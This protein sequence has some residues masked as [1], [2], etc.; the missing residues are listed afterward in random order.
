MMLAALV[1]WVKRVLEL[2]REAICPEVDGMAVLERVGLQGL[3]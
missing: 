1:F 3:E 2:G